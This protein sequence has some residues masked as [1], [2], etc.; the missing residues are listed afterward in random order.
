[1]V[2]FSVRIFPNFINQRKESPFHPTRRT[3]LFGN[4]APVTLVIIMAEDLFRVSESDSA[5]LVFP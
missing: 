3:K 4:F 1:M 2:V 5:F